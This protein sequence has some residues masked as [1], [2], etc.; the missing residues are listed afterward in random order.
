MKKRKSIGKIVVLVILF[1]VT[2]FL[3]ADKTG[4]QQTPYCYASGCNHK[5]PDGTNCQSTAIIVGQEPVYIG[6]Q[7]LWNQNRYS[8]L[9]VA[10][11]SYT[12]FDSFTYL[13]AETVGISRYDAPQQYQWVWN[14][15]WD[16]SGTVCT[17]GR[18]GTAPG[19]YQY[20][21]NQVCR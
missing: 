19:V 9:C 17:R 12:K 18:K 20:V 13:S 7:T 4:A 10:N 6:S 3:S 8:P 21:T 1:G 15:M 14:T 11:Y 5:D 2:M 16:G